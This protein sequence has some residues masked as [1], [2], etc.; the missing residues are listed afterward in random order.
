MLPGE[1]EVGDWDVVSPPDVEPQ[2]GKPNPAT[3]QSLTKEVRQHACREVA[4]T[5][6][7]D[8]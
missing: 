7:S 1:K 4:R 3:D 8:E 5:R 6:A 2:D